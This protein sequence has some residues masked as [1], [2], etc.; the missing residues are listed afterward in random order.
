MRLWIDDYRKP[1]GD[2]WTWAKTL[3]EALAHVRSDVT[4]EVISFDHD[5]GVK[6]LV[7]MRWV[8]TQPVA[9]WFEAEAEAGRLVHMPVWFIH[10]ANPEGRRQLCAI[11]LRAEKFIEDRKHATD[12]EEE[13]RGGKLL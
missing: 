1:P 9:K 7:N 8:D 13:L 11:L 4:I 6:D 5:L 3:E 12:I 10:S 2:D